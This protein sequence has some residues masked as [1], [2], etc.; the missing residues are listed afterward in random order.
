MVQTTYQ[1]LSFPVLSFPVLSGRSFQD[2]GC[3]MSL[4]PM[5][6]FVIYIVIYTSNDLALSSL[7]YS[8][9]SIFDAY[10]VWALLPSRMT[11]RKQCLLGLLRSFYSSIPI[12]LPLHPPPPP[13][14]S[15]SYVPP[16]HFPFFF[17]WLFICW[18]C[19]CNPAMVS[20]TSPII[21]VTI[22]LFICIGV[23]KWMLWDVGLVEVD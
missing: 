13:P 11:K 21:P 12:A 10:P 6:M 14:P 5:L 1:I 4:P 18:V 20:L 22:S 7:F 9:P 8:S 16:P 3:P 19:C 17:F 23:E 15:T 2:K